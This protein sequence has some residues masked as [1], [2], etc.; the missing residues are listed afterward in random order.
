MTDVG[1]GIFDML[2][3]CSHGQ[4]ETLGYLLVGKTFLTAHDEDFFATFRH[5]LDNLADTVFHIA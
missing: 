4:T 3:Y 5:I 2:L 1:E